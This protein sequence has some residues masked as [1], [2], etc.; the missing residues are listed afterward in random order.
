ML[1]G[2]GGQVQYPLDWV[3][4]LPS[5]SAPWHESPSVERT[6]VLTDQGDFYWY[7]D[8]KIPLLRSEDELVVA[9]REGVDIEAA[10]TALTAAGGA[11][12]GF[13]V[14]QRFAR[15]LVS[16]G[17][18]DMVSPPAP[19]GL[20][21]EA[22]DGVAAVAWSAPVLTVASG[23]SRVWLTDQ[24][25]VKLKPGVDPRA[26]F[27]TGYS[28]Y[29][30][31]FDG[32]WVGRF[33]DAGGL[34]ALR[35]TNDLVLDPRVEWSSPDFYAA[36]FL[37]VPEKPVEP[38]SINL[39]DCFPPTN[40]P[41][42]AGT[43]ADYDLDGDVDL[44]DFVLLKERIRSATEALAAAAPSREELG[45]V[46][47]S[48]REAEASLSAAAFWAALEAEARKEDGPFELAPG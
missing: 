4:C 43:A 20:P 14:S 12:D 5:D 29:E 6:P 1:D 30:A 48:A 7:F 27:A 11:L 42:G 22:L 10:L 36:G 15:G 33:A 23:R 45:R 46:A 38:L 31:L 47:A 34:E 26:F 21:L 25:V 39:E 19:G 40:E 16:L 44:A 28:H 8:E 35:R 2:A 41:A 18:I 13:R 37:W 3:G 32:Q 9:F 24:F 17:R